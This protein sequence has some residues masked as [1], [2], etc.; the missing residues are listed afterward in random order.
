M[1]NFFDLLPAFR[2]HAVHYNARKQGA[3]ALAG[4]GNMRALARELTTLSVSLPPDAPVAKG[5]CCL[6][7]CDLLSSMPF[8]S[9]SNE[10]PKLSACRFVRERNPVQLVCECLLLP[11]LFSAVSALLQRAGLSTNR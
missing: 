2:R 7:L 6:P 3:P 4:I 5:L 9:L 11:D 8:W 1:K 10:S